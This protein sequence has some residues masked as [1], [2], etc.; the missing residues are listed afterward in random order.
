M[1]SAGNEAND[2][3]ES[4]SGPN[5]PAAGKQLREIVIDTETTGLDISSDRIVEIGAVELVD[6]R[7][8]GRVF[9][10]FVNPG[11][12][13]TIPDDAVAIHGITTETVRNQP[14]FGEIADPFLDRK[15]VV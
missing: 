8:T 2:S 12:D 7:H 15:S 11:A 13:I 3:M 4:R 10:S 6:R 14:S 5:D 1:A 9:H